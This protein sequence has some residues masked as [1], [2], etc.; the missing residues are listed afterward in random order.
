MITSAKKTRRVIV[1]DTGYYTAGASA[2]LSA[3]IYEE[4]FNWLLCP[5]ERIT[6]PD[7]PTPASYSLEEAYYKTERDI[8]EIARKMMRYR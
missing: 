8:C 4:L 3:I 1:T 7:I 2:E 5:I 6:L